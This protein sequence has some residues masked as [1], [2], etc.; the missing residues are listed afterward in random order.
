MADL[1]Q[2]A[3][4]ALFSSFVAI[5]FLLYASS[6]PWYIGF[7]FWLWVLVPFLR[8][9]N[10][11][12]SGT[13]TP[14]SRSFILL[15]PFAS[16]LVASLDVFRF[17][18]RLPHRRYLP[19]LL[20]LSGLGYAYVIGLVRVGGFS[21]TMGLVTW[22]PP[23]LAALFILN[24]PHLYR[25][26][27]RVFVQMF[28]WSVF[29]LG[30]Y[31]IVQFFFLPAWDEFWMESCNMI[32]IGQPYPLQVRVYSLLDSPGPFAITLMVG[33]VFL[34]VQPS[35]PQVLAAVP[36]YISLLLARVRGAWLAW[37]I[38]VVAII[39]QLKGRLRTRLLGMVFVV[40]LLALPLVLQ[41]PVKQ[42]FSNRAQTLQN[43]EEDQSV[44]TRLQTY[45]ETSVEL[46]KSPVGHGLGSRTFD[47]GPVTVFWQLGWLGGLLYLSGLALLLWRLCNGASSSFLTKIIVGISAAHLA[48]FLAGPQILFGVT[49]F[50]FWILVSL[51]VLSL[52]TPHASVV[53]PESRSVP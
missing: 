35:A 38:A 7:V 13:F 11:Y 50:T 17:G 6:S 16:S 45:R 47:S 25:E 29:A 53:R 15:A 9:V 52:E 18:G 31:G 20:C 36:G 44:Q 48:H 46:L 23:V 19:F 2:L 21:A 1:H 5:S 28:T 10:D 33:L 22:L 40:A 24:R 8:R 41:G 27:R 12:L 49:G 39:F 26:Q 43:L 3:S 4:L 14:P 37:V 51:A 42:R 30:A 32:S 34:F